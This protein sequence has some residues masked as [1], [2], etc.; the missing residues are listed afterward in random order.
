MSIAGI[1]IHQQDQVRCLHKER[2]CKRRI[3]NIHSGMFAICP[4]K[5][6]FRLPCVPV[7][8]SMQ[9]PLFLT[10]RKAEIMILALRL[11]LRLHS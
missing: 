9:K 10:A 5:C 3:E 2:F 1:L 7:P 8:A 4:C 11:I 6:H